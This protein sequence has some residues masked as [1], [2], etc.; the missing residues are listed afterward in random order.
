MYHAE[1]RTVNTHTLARPRFDRRFYLNTDYSKYAIGA[2][3]SQK[4]DDG[5]R[6]FPPSPGIHLH[7]EKPLKILAGG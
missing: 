3:L 2:V 6:G 5:L 1:K 4:G 7:V